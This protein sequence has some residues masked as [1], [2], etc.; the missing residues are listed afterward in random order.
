[1]KISI[2]IPTYNRKNLLKKAIESAMRQDYDDIEII[3]S[4]NASNDGTDE[5]IKEFNEQLNLKY[6]RNTTN[7]GPLL[8]YKKCVY[9]YA[10]GDYILFLSD[11]D[12]LI[13]PTYIRRSVEH[14]E[15]NPHSYIVI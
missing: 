13:D 14:I 8:N 2:C 11:D 10:T 7:I 9:E 6:Y 1:M 4:D 12:E 15:R 3:I 5:T